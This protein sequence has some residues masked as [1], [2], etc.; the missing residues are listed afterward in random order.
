[1]SDPIKIRD[2]LYYH[3][4]KAYSFIYLVDEKQ[5]QITGPIPQP[6]FAG[7]VGVLSFICSDEEFE[8]SCDLAIKYL[9]E[10]LK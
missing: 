6:P 2:Y 10:K 5:M 8:K 7:A 4:G 9:K 3:N 1:M